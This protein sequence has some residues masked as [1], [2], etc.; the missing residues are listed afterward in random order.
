V[1]WYPRAKSPGYRVRAL[2]LIEKISFVLKEHWKKLNSV[3]I[4]LYCLSLWCHVG[5]GFSRHP[6]VRLHQLTTAARNKTNYPFILPLPPIYL[7]T[8][9]PENP[10]LLPEYNTWVVSR[11]PSKPSAR[12]HART[13]AAAGGGHGLPPAP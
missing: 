6:Y 11:S 12:T 3:L 13:R 1:R 10:H 2:N 7:H 9:S 4:G 5:V 8:S